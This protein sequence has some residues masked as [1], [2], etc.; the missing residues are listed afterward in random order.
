M[1][2]RYELMNGRICGWFGAL[3]VAVLTLS[4]TIGARAQ[5]MA[6]P[7]DQGLLVVYGVQAPTREGDLDHRETIFF[8]LSR[9][10]SDRVYVRIF[11]PEMSGSHDFR[12]GGGGHSQTIFR[13]FGGDGSLSGIVPPEPVTDGAHPQ[14]SRRAALMAARPGKILREVSYGSDPVTDGQWVSLGSLR[15]RQGEI[16]GDRA[17]FRLEVLGM[18]GDDGNGYNVDVSLS[19]DVHRRPEGLE[20][21]AYQPTV[22]WPGGD[23]GTR[24]ELQN[25][26][27]GAL[28]VQNFDGAAGDL[29]LNLMYSDIALRASGQNT[30]ASEAVTPEEELLAITLRGGFETPN[31]M[32]LSVFDES[33]AALPILMP[34]RQSGD[35]DR[36]QVL[37]R[38]RAL[39]DCSSVAFDGSPDAGIESTTPQFS[40]RWDYGDGATASEPVI[41]YSYAAA[42]HYEARLRV[43]EAGTRAARGSESAVP[44]HVRVA[45]KAVA[46]RD[47]VV[48]PGDVVPFDARAS[49]ASDSPITRYLWNFGDG[50]V[51]DQD[52]IDKIYAESGAYRTIL[53]VMDGSNHPC[54]F[55]VSTRIVTV[56]FAPVAEAGTDQ[57]SIVGRVVTLDGAASYDVDGTISSH[58]WDMGDGT[59][60]TGARINHVYDA[61]GVYLVALEVRDDSGVTNA[62]TQD[63][64]TIKVN[65]PPVPVI[66]GPTAPVAVGEAVI[67]DGRGSNDADGVILSHL[68]DF[69][70]GAMG[71][72]ET[73]QYAWASPGVYE[74]ILSVTDNSGTSS[75]MQT[76]R[77]EV[78]VNTRPVAQ[79]GPDQFVT[80][81]EVQ[82]DGSASRDI[83]GKV[84]QYLWE[85]GDGRSGQGP[86]PVHYYASAGTYQVA[87]TVKD[88][89]GAPQSQ[90]RDLMMVTIN[91]TPI[92]DAGPALTVAPGEEFV[93]DAGASLDPDGQIAQYLWTFE[94]GVTKPGARV[95][96]H[97]ATPGLHR[98]SL[99]VHDDFVGGSAQ[100]FSEVLITVNAQPVAQAGPDVFVAPDE[101]VR[102]DAGGSFDR[103]GNLISYRWEFDDLQNPLEAA[104]IER[105]WPTAG[106]FNARLVVRDESG[107]A[108]STAVDTVTIRINHP[109]KAEAGAVIDTD[110]LRITLDGGGSSD[111]DGDKLIYLWDFGDG[112]EPMYGRQVTHVY[113][114]AGRFPVTLQV[115]DGSG[116]SNAGDVDAT[117]VIINAPPIAVAGGNR[118]VC[119]GQSILFDA[120]ASSDADGD[121]L[122]YGWDFGDGSD[123]VIINPTKIYE[124]PGT[125]PVTL[126]VT[127]ESRSARGTDLDRVAVIVREGPIADAGADRTICV[128]QEIRMDG[129]GSTDADGSVNGFEWTFGDG[130]RA[131]GATPTKSFDKPGT[132][133]VTLTITG[134]AT[135]QCSPLDTDV[136]TMTVLPA[137]SQNID[138]AARAAIGVAVP[139]TVLLDGRDQAGGTVESHDWQF[140][141]GGSAKGA[142]VE[143]AF[144][145]AGVYQA[146]LTTRLEGGQQ[147]C[148][149]LVSTH[150][151]TINAPPVA[152]I[153]APHSVAVDALVVLDGSASVDPDGVITNFEWDFGD[154]T[155][156]HGVAGR[157]RYTQAGSY[158]VRL[159]LR[160]DADVANSAVVL[161]HQMVVNPVPLAGLHT[162]AQLCANVPHSWQVAAAEDVAVDWQ[163]G[164]GQSA[165]GAHI[166]HEFA[167]P[168][169]YPVAVTTDDGRGLANSVSREEIYA[170]VN[171]PPLANAGPDRV[172][173]PGQ[174]VVF[175]TSSYDPDG[176]V[177]Q[178]I[179]RFSD[180]VTL[181]GQNTRRTFEKSGPVAVELSVVD[182]S[183]SACNGGIDVAMLQINAPPVVDAGPDRTVPVGAVHDVLHFDASEARDPD[184]QGLRISWDFGDVT[185][186]TGAVARH[187]YA[188]AGV[189]T[190]TVT[191]SDS[192]GLSCGIATDTATVTAIAREPEN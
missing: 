163:F 53:R 189:Y 42:G 59:Q 14:K 12:Y 92:A 185:G 139:F 86:R 46:G 112:S 176:R 76:T 28:T 136:V 93:L 113:A 124:R 60:L 34:P 143:H 140:S 94:D 97:I 192:S 118:D 191:A 63:F 89:S 127:D 64:V 9:D 187:R 150:K 13:V 154:G 107:V 71:E 70:D 44:V 157:H 158:Q 66:A 182:D 27:A 4:Q 125:Y 160:D 20:M 179:W 62:T 5:D 68:W 32:T 170:R 61:P 83:D 54:N 47:V 167:R 147:D 87:L 48:A 152:H 122:R 98:L 120:S 24:V 45:P 72:G 134:D 52:E 40:Y 137:R 25:P 132:Y 128:N 90:H 159:M 31:D 106:V 6:A 177:T 3:L 153:E 186:A 67:L 82:F 7:V 183:G 80:A 65:A 56:N 39:A 85:F 50:T 114:H 166:K 181:E 178:W 169:L 188:S 144:A 130:S 21:I 49:I 165:T 190:V 102:F 126:R 174:E 29:R 91:A 2:G 105:A 96:H 69:G 84:A 37:P 146:T 77:F 23:F 138:A 129:A 22:R 108:N 155:T 117:T 18:G 101:T 156:G 135:G 103:D 173:C 141:D 148:G 41:V 133:A 30:W 19:R 109:P 116:L 1:M 175:G 88:D 8:S 55:G 104:V 172:V 17:W 99:V 75:A 149:E 74:V 171:A 180:G 57:N 164:D 168:G 38:A 43:L 11:D 145:E 142:A 161:S 121:L 95:A 35:A 110:V 162:P 73:A 15:A 16:I 51:S 33:G 184:G 10:L 58:V 131:S 36:P 81:S 111:A 26:G 78:I 100:D 79:A 115:D 151:I 119:S 123:S